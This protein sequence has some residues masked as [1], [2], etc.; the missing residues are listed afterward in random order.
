MAIRLTRLLGALALVL[1]VSAVAPIARVY[2]CSCIQMTPEL[3]LAN[4][5]VA[6]VGVVT[7]I[8]D[9]ISG[10]PIISSGDPVSY[11][12]AVEKMLKGSAGAELIVSSNRDG[13]SCGMTFGLAERWRIYTYADESGRL[14]TGIC[15]GNELLETGVP[16]PEIAAPEA[17]PPLA[18]FV[19]GGA[20]LAVIAVSLFAFTRPARTGDGS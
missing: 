9:T 16:I 19:A 6:F 20:I 17:P 10:G 4:A 2:A 15:S 8:A 14:A 1:L 18:V 11:T 5:N 3:A 12:F 7:T 13:A